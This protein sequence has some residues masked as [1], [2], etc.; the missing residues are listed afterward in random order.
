MKNDR[1]FL[2]SIYTKK[3]ARTA[4]KRKKASF[5]VTAVLVLGITASTAALIQFEKKDTPINDTVSND[6]IIVQPLES[7]ENIIPTPEESKENA[8]STESSANNI[9]LLTCPDSDSNTEAIRETHITDNFS[10]TT[11]FDSSVFYDTLQEYKNE[12][13][14]F[15]IALNIDPLTTFTYKGKY[16]S[17]LFVNVNGYYRFRA[18]KHNEF[19]DFVSGYTKWYHNG[20]NNDILYEL[21]IKANG[22]DEEAAAMLREYIKKGDYVI[23]YDLVW[24][25][26]KTAEEIAVFRKQ[27]DE[28]NAIW[29]E[30]NDNGN[31]ILISTYKEEAKRLAAEGYDLE[32]ITFNGVT[33][34]VGKLTSEQILHF[35]SNDRFDYSCVWLEA[36]YEDKYTLT[37]THPDVPN[38]DENE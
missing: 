12:D 30:Y 3:A 5:A 8:T 35:N 1:Q 37:F 20:G 23:Y 6:N 9:V 22:G 15:L 34:L 32:C 19:N 13:A 31:S 2:E 25:K 26:D 10:L 7:T 4:A 33:K 24:S 11:P 21:E 29:K 18:D 14:R 36:A 16:L 28:Y 38:I 27:C 17:E